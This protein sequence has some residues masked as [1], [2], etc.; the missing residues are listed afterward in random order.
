LK[1]LKNYLKSEKSGVLQ[2]IEFRDHSGLE[3][4][5]L[6]KFGDEVPRR[7]TPYSYAELLAENSKTL[8]LTPM[9]EPL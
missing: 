4:E 9:Q 8:N 5:D 7:N 3:N 6:H 2:G 1:S